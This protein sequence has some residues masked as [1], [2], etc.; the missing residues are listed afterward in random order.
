M[1]RQKDNAK[2]VFLKFCSFTTGSQQVPLQVPDVMTG[3]LYCAISMLHST[4]TYLP[5]Y[6]G[7]SVYEWLM[8]SCGFLRVDDMKRIKEVAAFVPELIPLMQ[9]PFEGQT[10]SFE[11]FSAF[12]DSTSAFLWRQKNHRILASFLHDFNR[13]AMKKSSPATL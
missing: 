1:N 12:W 8:T 3:E 7:E 4:E 11:E 2:D 10:V 9:H 5:C 13:L 6:P